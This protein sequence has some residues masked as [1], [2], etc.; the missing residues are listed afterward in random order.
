MD[1]LVLEMA[2]IGASTMGDKEL[3]YFI[4]CHVKSIG[5]RKKLFLLLRN[6]L[7][8]EDVGKEQPV[9]GIRYGD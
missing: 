4:S 1:K 2:R 5:A 3:K 9:E 6:V 7:I 8:K